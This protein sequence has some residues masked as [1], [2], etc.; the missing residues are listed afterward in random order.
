MQNHMNSNRFNVL[1][2]HTNENMSKY[3]DDRDKTVVQSVDCFIS[4]TFSFLFTA[5]FIDHKSVPKV[6][7]TTSCSPRNE[8]S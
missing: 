1:N 3:N 5:F 2:R 4:V 7:P 6:E 8:R